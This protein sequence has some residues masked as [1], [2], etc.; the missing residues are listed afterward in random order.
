[1]ND[2]FGSVVVVD[3][4]F[5][6]TANNL[7]N[8][9][10]MVA[11]VL[12]GN[13][14]Y[15][16]TMRLWR[17]EFGPAPPFNIGPDS[18]F[19]AYSAQAEMT[20]FKVL[21]WQFPAHI[22]DQHTAYIAA[23][24]VLLPYLPDKEERAARKK[25]L[26]G[27]SLED[28]CHS[29]RLTGWSGMD[30]N[31]IRKSIGD[32]TWVGR[33][34]P[35]DIITYCEEDVRMEMLLLRKQLRPHFDHR[36]YYGTLPAA[37]VPHIIWWSEYA[38][39]VV[40]SVQARGTLI[41]VPLYNLIRENRLAMIDAVRRQFDPSYNDPDPIW[42]PDGSWK[43]ARVEK[44][45]VR[46][47]LPWWPRL[48]SGRLNLEGDTFRMM[49]S[50]PG[51]TNLYTAKKAIAFIRRDLPIGKDGR[52]R[53]SL[54][55]F[56]TATGRNAHRRS[57]FNAHAG[58]RSLMVFPPDMIG[59]YLDWRTQE[60]GVAAALSGDHALAEAYLG[61]DVYYSLARDNNLTADPDRHH[62]KK[63]NVGQRQ[64]MKSLQLAINYGMTIRSLARS[65]GVHPIIAAE[66]LE[67]HQKKYHTFHTWRSRMLDS[68]MVNRR[69]R[70]KFGWTLRLSSD[71][72]PRTLF[73][74]PIQGGSA[75]MLRLA[76]VRLCGVGIVPIM[77]VHDACLLE[78]N[79]I[80]Q[81]QLAQEIM[82]QTG[83]DTCNGLEIGVDGGHPD[84][85]LL[86]GAHYHDKRPE[87]VKLWD[88]LMSALEA[89][90]AIPK[91]RVA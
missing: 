58:L 39:K 12:D 75:E 77:L 85:L 21:G 44:W 33:Y 49:S 90:G 47:G 43:E 51:V 78:L 17:G 11:Y 7:P 16:R 52:N 50:Y 26:G 29:Y 79:N 81:L 19:V 91:R 15:V 2:K 69:I 4:E 88:T 32:G 34:S 54:F 45:M 64:Q 63:H 1:V 70:T 74:F 62:W 40:A 86:E 31:T 13:L 82:Q 89:V 72:N 5:E 57:I 24:N 61:G 18:L 84:E 14:R 35:Q 36:G 9:L 67:R 42:T 87:A 22:F 6:V 60:I 53:P 46:A 76:A 27:R 28:A 37:D 66:I 48:E 3:F 25:L 20:C 80:E 8:P 10:C 41:D 71:P 65:L 59:A 83:R 23:T 56:G 73:N 68:A 55:P 30:K 38:A